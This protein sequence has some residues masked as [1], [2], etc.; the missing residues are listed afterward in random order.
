VDPKNSISPPTMVP[1]AGAPPQPS[2]ATRA[3]RGTGSERAESTSDLVTGLLGD[4]KD[5]AAAHGQALRGEVS[6]ELQALASTLKMFTI[7]LAVL[8]IGALLFV[9]AL[10]LFVA[11]MAAIPVWVTYGGFALALVAGGVYLLKAKNPAQKV[12]DGRA[13]LVPETSMADAKEGVDFLKDQ[14][15]RLMK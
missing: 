4:V 11:D 10:A 7:S 12:S 8:S 6:E 13:D 5:L 1:Q 14:A 15:K 9:M 3:A 2:A